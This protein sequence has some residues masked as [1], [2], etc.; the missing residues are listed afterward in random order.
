ML[1]QVVVESAIGNS[2]TVP[3]A[4]TTPTNTN[5]STV[6]GIRQS[7]LTLI[8]LIHQTRHRRFFQFQ[9]NTAGLYGGVRIALDYNLVSSSGWNNAGP[10][11]VLYS[12]TGTAGSWSVLN[13]NAWAKS[14]WEAAGITATSTS[15][16]TN[17]YFR[18]YFTG[19]STA[20]NANANAYIDNVVIS[21]CQLPT[22]PTIAKSFGTNPIPVGS[23]STLTFTLTNPNASAA[24]SGV[25]FT[26]VLPGGLV[27][28]TPNGLTNN[29]GGTATAAA[30]TQTISLSG[31]AIGAASSC[32]IL[33]SVVG[34]AAGSYTNT[35][36]NI[37]STETGPNTSTTPNVGFARA[38]LTVI[39][40]P[41]ISKSFTANPIFTGE[42]TTLKFT[43]ANPNTSTTLT[44]INF[45]IP[46]PQVWMW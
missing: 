41:V 37:T 29:C 5:T 3:A 7:W 39:V 17:V 11:Y 2:A 10:W 18:V 19:A 33:V 14:S 34:N 28:N 44:G 15:N 4:W 1:Q 46:C 12:A 38:S 45:L 43:I 25:S 13:T 23:A 27:I 16:A 31:G 30:G 40:P 9:V 24:L 42:T 35:S 20:Q 26:D 22:V 6:W 32:T 21:G 8:R 36:T